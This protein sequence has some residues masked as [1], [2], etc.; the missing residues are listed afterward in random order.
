M[1]APR[2]KWVDFLSADLWADKIKQ[3]KDEV[4]WLTTNSL[5]DHDWWLAQ[6][7]NMWN[8]IEKIGGTGCFKNTDAQFLGNSCCGGS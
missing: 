8:E 1:D 7:K 2:F 6:F 5:Q 3:F 4:R